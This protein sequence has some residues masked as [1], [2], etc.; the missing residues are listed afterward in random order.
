MQ[1]IVAQGNA[2]HS[3]AGQRNARKQWQCKAVSSKELNGKVM[4]GK[5]RMDVY[6]KGQQPIARNES[7]R[8][9][10]QI[11]VSHRSE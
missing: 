7:Q 1:P 6:C 5:K 9:D 10:G 3:S 8:T 2:P 11:S 4:P